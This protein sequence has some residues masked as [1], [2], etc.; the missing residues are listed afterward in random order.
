MEHVWDTKYH[1]KLSVSIFNCKIIQDHEVKVGLNW[2]FPV[3]VA[4]S[5]FLFHFFKKVKNDRRS[6]LEWPKTDKIWKSGKY[7]NPREQHKKWPFSTFK[8][9]WFFMIS[10]WNFVLTYTWRLSFTR[11]PFLCKIQKFSLCFGKQYFCRI[12]STSFRILKILK[13]RD[14]RMIDTTIPNLL[15]RTNRLYL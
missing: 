3:W 9:R 12:L 1:R 13:I 4:W 10:T 8:T 2:K 5:M 14:S 6:L 11:I 7:R 15:L